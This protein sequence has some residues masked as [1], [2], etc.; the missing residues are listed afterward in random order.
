MQRE[1]KHVDCSASYNQCWDIS[2]VI[3]WAYRKQGK[4]GMK[5]CGAIAIR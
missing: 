3:S 1:V 5:L 4:E 2:Q